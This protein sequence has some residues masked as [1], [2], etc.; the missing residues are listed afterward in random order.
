MI[1]MPAKAL[2]IAN[3]PLITDPNYHI[4]PDIN[5]NRVSYIDVINGQAQVYVYNIKTDKTLQLTH[6]TASTPDRPRIYG[7]YVVYND[8]RTGSSQIYLYNLS[9]DSEQAITKSPGNRAFADI[10]GTDVVWE[11]SSNHA[12]ANDI[13]MY[14]IKFHITTQITNDADDE[15][16]PSVGSNWVTWTKGEGS[17]A[18]IYAYNLAT[19]RT[20]LVTDAS[21]AQDHSRCFKNTVVWDDQRRGTDFSDVY[22]MDLNGGSEQLISDGTGYDGRPAIY[23]Q[24]IVYVDFSSTQGDI[25][26]Y[27]IKTKQIIQITNDPATQSQPSIYKN[28]LVW[29]DYRNGLPEIYGNFR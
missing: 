27:N 18:D 28:K 7:N 1:V 15:Y 14:D 21:Y 9:D 16:N 10:W 23:G 8:D 4:F 17:A 29:V 11:D 19:H 22:M 20:R 25:K 24:N 6:D 3:K 26:D 12:N 13:F 5:G 2:S